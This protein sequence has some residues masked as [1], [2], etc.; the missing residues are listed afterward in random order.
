M[1]EHPDKPVHV[2]A[3]TYGGWHLQIPNDPIFEPA[4][5]QISRSQSHHLAA[6]HFVSRQQDAVR[7]SKLNNP[8]LPKPLHSRLSMQWPQDNRNYDFPSFDSAH[9]GL[10][11]VLGSTKFE[12]RYAAANSNY[13]EA[14]KN[15]PVQFHVE[16]LAHESRSP[17]SG[18][19]PLFLQPYCTQGFS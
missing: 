16:P 17:I 8:S 1:A 7:C 11:S 9:V 3:E 15:Q 10:G 19:S 12:A 2:R 6:E 14:F 18:L 4:F 13:T 5:G